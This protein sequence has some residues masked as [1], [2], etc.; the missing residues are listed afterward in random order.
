MTTVTSLGPPRF[1]NGIYHIKSGIASSHNYLACRQE[2][3]AI[4]V[5]ADSIANAQTVS[6]L[7][8]RI[9]V[10]LTRTVGYLSCW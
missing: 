1:P 8:D 10:I 5:T 7:L 3:S 6:S 9:T 4:F 2:G